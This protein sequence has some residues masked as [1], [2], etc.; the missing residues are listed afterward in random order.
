[1]VRPALKVAGTRAST[2]RVARLRTSTRTVVRRAVGLS[3]ESRQRTRSPSVT[4]LVVALSETAGVG[5]PGSPRSSSAV[6]Q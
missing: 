6:K 4:R 3:S 2:C 5:K 1:M